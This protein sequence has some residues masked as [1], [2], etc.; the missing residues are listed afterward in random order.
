MELDLQSLFGLHLHGK[1]PVPAGGS[2]SL[3][4]KK[5]DASKAWVS[6]NVFP[7]WGWAYG[8]AYFLSLDAKQAQI[9][10]NEKTEKNCSEVHKY[11]A[12][13][14][15]KNEISMLWYTGMKGTVAL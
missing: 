3:E 4:F 7:L 10:R 1:M 12:L 11:R 6:A 9:L 5:D 8:T 13:E 15:R 2:W 14:M